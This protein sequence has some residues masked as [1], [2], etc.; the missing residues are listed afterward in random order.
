MNHLMRLIT[1][2]AQVVL[3]DGVVK[4]MK[5]MEKG[6]MNK[7]KGTPAPAPTPG[8][9]QDGNRTLKKVDKY[10][11]GPNRDKVNTHFCQICRNG[12]IPRK[13]NIMNFLY[14]GTG[15]CMDYWINGQMSRL[16][17]HMCSVI[18]YYAYNTCGCEIEEPNKLLNALA[19]KLKEKEDVQQLSRVINNYDEEVGFARGHL[20]DLIVVY[21]QPERNTTL[22]QELNSTLAGEVCLN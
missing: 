2:V 6:K 19:R 1:V 10:P 16:P 9:T 8:P 3:C 21:D 12:R 15:T 5:G 20:L 17:T 13:N 14:I 4:G 7:D 11:F 22:Y 18:Q